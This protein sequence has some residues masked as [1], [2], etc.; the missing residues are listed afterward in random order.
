MTIITHKLNTTNI[1]GIGRLQ[2]Q[3]VSVR[4]GQAINSR[5][6]LYLR[7]QFALQMYAEPYQFG[8]VT[9]ALW[10]SGN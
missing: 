8:G 9:W 1:G 3:V 4:L 6:H 5:F 2:V 10:P 7:G